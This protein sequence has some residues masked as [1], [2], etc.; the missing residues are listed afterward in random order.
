MPCNAKVVLYAKVKVDDLKKLGNL[1]KLS[2]AYTNGNPQY[3]LSKLVSVEIDSKG[4]ATLRYIGNDWDEGVRML[5]NAINYMKKL[6][7]EV[8]DVGKPETHRHDDPTVHIHTG[9][10]H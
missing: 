10:T 5:S 6:N 9:V 8:S 2:N 3:E 7:V 1:K 4:N